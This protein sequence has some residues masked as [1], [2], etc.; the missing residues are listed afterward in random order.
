[1]DR[2]LSAD[3][4]IQKSPICVVQRNKGQVAAVQVDMNTSRPASQ[5]IAAAAP[6]T[7]TASRL[8]VGAPIA[9]ALHTIALIAFLAGWTYLGRAWAIHMRAEAVP[10]RLPLYLSTLAMEWSVFGYI[11]WGVRKRG[12]SLREL[13]G[14]RWSK[15]MGNLKDFGIAACY[16]LVALPILALT[17]HLLHI[18]PASQSTRFIMP[19]GALEIGLWILLSITAGICE[20][21]IFR[22][23]LQRQFAGWTRN[24]IVGLLISAVLF[25]AG[26]IY[27]G[28]K[29]AIVIGVFGALF[30]TLA[31]I[32][33]SLKPGIIA[34]SFQ[35]AVGGIVFALSRK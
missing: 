6:S 33:R 27:Q 5:S 30:G 10:S 21:T 2:G 19:V 17:S 24:A 12:I 28:G 31:L 22:G 4:F 7:A 1:M 29:Q 26:H 15:G 35:D 18:D 32:C 11:V 20:E 9:S 13:V 3:C 23:Y 16:E 8:A 14:P 25:G 34:H